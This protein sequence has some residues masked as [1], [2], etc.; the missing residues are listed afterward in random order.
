MVMLRH[1]IGHAAAIEEYLTAP[2]RRMSLLYIQEHLGHHLYNELGGM[3]A[4]VREIPR[5]RMPEILL[6][7]APKSEMYGRI[8][9]IFPELAGKV[10]RTPRNPDGLARHAYE[11][12]LCLVRPTDDYVSRDLANRIIRLAEQDPALDTDRRVYD[13]LIERGF[14]LVMLGLRVENRTLVD[15]TGFFIEVIDTMAEKLGRLAV[16]VDGHDTRA[17]EDGVRA[18]ESHGEAIASRS[19]ADVE[20]EILAA[21]RQRYRDRQDIEVVSTVGAS[22]NATLFWCVRSA[23]FV[24]PWGAGLAKY[25]WVCNRPG[26]VVAGDRFLRHGE[27]LTIHLYDAREFMERPT[28]V[29]FFSADDVEDDPEAP[30]LIGLADAY[31]VNYRVRPGAVRTRVLELLASLQHSDIAGQAVV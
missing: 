25:R 29:V 6:I 20:N 28:R 21:L 24:C 2:E 19:V 17:T 23:A 30:L 27:F 10:D 13:Y 31:R 5:E 11:T 26:L 14:T 4:V 1:V 3:D 15:Q 9:E 22:M 12:R 7:N 18:F 16:V 8:D